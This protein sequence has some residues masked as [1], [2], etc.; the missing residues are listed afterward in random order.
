MGNRITSFRDENY[1]LSNF[2]KC[3]IVMDGMTYPSVENA[4]QAAKTLSQRER[5]SFLFCSAAQSKKLG[6]SITL[7]PD[8]E[9]VKIPVMRVLLFQKFLMNPLRDQLL[10][11]EDAVLIEGNEWNDTFWGMCYAKDAGEL[12]GRNVLGQL[13]MEVREHYR[14]LKATA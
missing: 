4:F 6:R 11:T 10:F 3:D 1:F 14:I 2:W 12:V 5:E 9:D 7:R 8:W 13:L